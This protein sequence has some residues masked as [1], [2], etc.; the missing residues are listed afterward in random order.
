MATIRRKVLHR[1][2]KAEKKND[3]A[4]VAPRWD[5]TDEWI[6]GLSDKDFDIVYPREFRATTEDEIRKIWEKDIPGDAVL[7]A[8]WTHHKCSWLDPETGTIRSRLWCHAQPAIDKL[9][10]DVD[11]KDKRKDDWA[12]VKCV[13]SELHITS[14]ANSNS[15][16]NKKRADT[17]VTT[18]KRMRML[19]IVDGKECTKTYLYDRLVA[20]KRAT[21]VKSTTSE[22]S[23]GDEDEEEAAAT[24]GAVEGEDE[25]EEIEEKTTSS[26]SEPSPPRE[27]PKGKEKK[28]AAAMVQMSTGSKEKVSRKRQRTSPSKQLP[29]PGSVGPAVH[30]AGRS[31]SQLESENRLLSAQ[32]QQVMGMNVGMLGALG[33]VPG[34]AAAKERARIYAESLEL[35]MHACRSTLDVA[36]RTADDRGKRN[37]EQII[38]RTAQEYQ[39]W[40]DACGAEGAGDYRWNAAVARGTKSE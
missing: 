12:R 14:L 34:D 6:E 10:I 9:I 17:N 38:D 37:I 36:V 32:L 4:F 19:E 29:S 40:M 1:R 31:A 21:E 16:W 3:V 20:M 33:R 13:Y 8:P 26:E 30:A 24:S 28:A 11:K 27:E 7:L 5:N 25:E 23:S 15:V 39:R 22:S 35:L 18:A 2:E